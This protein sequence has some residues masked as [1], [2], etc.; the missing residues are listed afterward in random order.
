MVRREPERTKSALDFIPGHHVRMWEER[1]IR[2][3]PDARIAKGISAASGRHCRRHLRLTCDTHTEGIAKCEVFRIE[4]VQTSKLVR[5]DAC[6]LRSDIAGV[7]D[8]LE[9]QL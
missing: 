9:G 2:R 6:A 5:L 7:E 3:Y 4:L 8:N 1:L